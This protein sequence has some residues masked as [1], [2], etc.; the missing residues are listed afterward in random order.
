MQDYMYS[1]CFSLSTCIY[2]RG[3]TN[4]L[5]PWIKCL[6]IRPFTYSL[7]IV[8]TV[9][10]HRSNSRPGVCSRRDERQFKH[11]NERM[12]M[13]FVDSMFAWCNLCGLLTVSPYTRTM[14]IPRRLHTDRP[15][16]G[17]GNECYLL[18][19]PPPGNKAQ[20]RKVQPGA[21]FHS[22]SGWPAQ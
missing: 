18:D 6:S 7:D 15:G 22:S 1:T 3:S 13:T 14:I 21:R 11:S 4:R 17:E 16:C 12:L 10:R 8:R 2:G 19:M 20:P 9:G 5:D